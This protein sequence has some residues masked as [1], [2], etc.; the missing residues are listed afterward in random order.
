[1]PPFSTLERE[2]AH[3]DSALIITTNESKVL[4]Y[5]VHVARTVYCVWIPYPTKYSSEKLKGTDL[6]HHLGAESI[7]WSNVS[8]RTEE[9][10]YLLQ[11]KTG[12]SEKV[13]SRWVPIPQKKNKQR[14]RT[15]K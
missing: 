13:R 6:V 1:L 8:K 15:H 3:H 11:L 4:R 10:R 12:T 14:W 7:Q 5:V 9:L 2:K